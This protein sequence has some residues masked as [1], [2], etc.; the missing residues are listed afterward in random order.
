[1]V[2]MKTRQ[3]RT[4]FFD[5]LPLELGEV[6]G[7][8]TRFLLYTVP[9]QVFYNATRKLVLKG[10]DAVVFVADSGIDKME[11]NLESL[12][13]LDENLREQGLML[14]GMPFVIQYNKRDLP[15]V[16]SVEELEQTLN[17]RGVPSFEA[18]AASGHG[19][20]ETLHAVSRLLF[21]RLLTDLRPGGRAATAAAGAQSAPGP[22]SGP[23]RVPAMAGRAGQAGG[24]VPG[25]PRPAAPAPQRARTGGVPPSPGVS[26]PAPEPRLSADPLVGAHGPSALHFDPSAPEVDD[27]ALPL[28]RPLAG[29][30]RGQAPQVAERIHDAGRGSVSGLEITEPEPVPDLE[31]GYASYGHVVDLEVEK[32]AAHPSSAAPQHDSQESEAFGGLIQDP[33]RRREASGPGR[34][35]PAG[36]VVTKQVSV[37]VSRAELKQGNTIRILVDVRVE[38]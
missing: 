16:Y 30:A 19:V 1:M 20:Y 32:G 21:Q 10:A 11:G 33:L 27:P 9:G 37:V 23:Q 7:F 18:A 28:A 3:D 5:F 35:A 4:L 36:P 38:S 14:E 26:R 12:R 17:P 6:H 34:R 15:N 31:P 24:A 8:R 25:A 2:S 22:A 13:N 29:P